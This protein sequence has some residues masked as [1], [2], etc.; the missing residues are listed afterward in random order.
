MVEKRSFRSLTVPP[1]GSDY[2]YS[3]QLG[4][5]I[6]LIR[7]AKRRLD[8]IRLDFSDPVTEVVA[9]HYHRAANTYEAILHLALSGF[10]VQGQM[11]LRP[12]LEAAITADWAR[13][14]RNAVAR[15]YVLHRKYA[16]KLWMD[17]RQKTGIYQDAVT[18]EELT[19][20]EFKEARRMFGQ[21]AERSWT[22]VSLREMA[23]DIARHSDQ[24][25][26]RLQWKAW[27]DAGHPMINW[28]LHATGVGS[29]QL[30]EQDTDI[31]YI[32]SGPSNSCILDTLSVA[33]W[34]YMIALGAMCEELNLEWINNMRPL[35]FAAWCSFKD[36]SEL[37][38]L[39]PTD[40]CPCRSGATYVSCHGRLAGE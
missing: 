14:H 29:W 22:G 39:G 38:N 5:C 3:R 20:A 33:W 28:T 16:L 36:P 19:A 2:P 10:G 13:H 1:P 32:I 34:M 7:Y 30:M 12:L 26:M 37:Q 9:V 17:S 25:S 15:R 35:M 27:M 23:D 11:L 18:A 40:P 6:E 21:Y 31:A 8:G 24:P 4:P